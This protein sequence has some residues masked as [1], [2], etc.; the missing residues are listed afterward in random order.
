M[1]N[2]SY[3]NPEQNHMFPFYLSGNLVFCYVFFCSYSHYCCYYY[4]YFHPFHHPYLEKKCE[5]TRILK[6][7]NKIADKLIDLYIVPVAITITS[8]MTSI[9]LMKSKVMSPSKIGTTKKENNPVKEDLN[10]N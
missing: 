9:M 8:T 2:I 3:M 10:S 1:K 4:C 6:D 7:V 5:K